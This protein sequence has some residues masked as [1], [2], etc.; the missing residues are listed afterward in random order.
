MYSEYYEKHGANR[1]DLLSNADV[2]FQTLAADRANIAALRRLDVDRSSARVLDVGCGSGS[3]LLQFLR[4]GFNPGNLH[5]IDTS[6]ERIL[7]GRT[8]LPTLDFRVES[9]DRLPFE[10]E[11][12]DIVFES[13]TLGTLESAQLLSS[14]AHE[15]LRVTKKNGHVM[16]TDWRYSRRGSGVKTAMNRTRIADLFDVGGSTVVVAR[17]AGALVPP[18]G[19]R[20]S[21]LAPSLYFLLQAILPPAV[22]QITTVLRKL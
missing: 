15:M 17:E 22:G 20:L 3:S 7:Q 19:R 6:E 2:V 14:I 10:D 4:L 18:I 9:A 11:S 1:N 16:L 5:G 13:T 8:L 21:R 12:F